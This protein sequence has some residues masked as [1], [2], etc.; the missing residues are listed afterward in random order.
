MI[1]IDAA[2]RSATKRKPRIR[3]I[4]RIPTTDPSELVSLVN[5]IRWLGNLREE[6]L[7]PP[8]ACL[9]GEA[10]WARSLPAGSD[11]PSRQAGRGL[12]ANQGGAFQPANLFHLPGKPAGV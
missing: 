6:D 2:R 12:A 10:D 4:T 11:S 5:E 3:R 9:A 8:R 7:R 1:R